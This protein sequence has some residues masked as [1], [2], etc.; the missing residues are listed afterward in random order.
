[1]K[2]KDN[3]WTGLIWQENGVK[4]KINEVEDNV[5][6]NFVLLWLAYMDQ[7]GFIHRCMCYM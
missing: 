7:M 2:E 1:M 4:K 3:T 5:V 6:E